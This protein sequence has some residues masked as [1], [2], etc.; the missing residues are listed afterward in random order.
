MTEKLCKQYSFVDIVLV[1]ILCEQQST[2]RQVRLKKI[3]PD[4]ISVDADNQE[5]N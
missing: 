3:N 4:S 2:I 1:L 5:V